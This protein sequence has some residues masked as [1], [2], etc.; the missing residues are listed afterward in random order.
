MLTWKFPRVVIVEPDEFDPWGVFLREELM[1]EFEKH[2]IIMG[3][4]IQD[5]QPP[6]FLGHVQPTDGGSSAELR[7]AHT[8][9]YTD[10]SYN[11]QTKKMSVRCLMLCMS[12]KINCKCI[13]V[14]H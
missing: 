14:Y 7:T 3:A 4:Q 2:G 5:S 1:Q 10:C 12:L 6:W 11:P 8:D 13:C 9:R